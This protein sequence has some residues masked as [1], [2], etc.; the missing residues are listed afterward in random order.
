MTV[1]AGLCSTPAKA[2]RTR[3]NALLLSLA[4]ELRTERV[5]FTAA[6]GGDSLPL[7]PL[8]ELSPMTMLAAQLACTRQE[9]DW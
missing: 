3:C 5:C 8:C 9:G 4:L 7:P 2:R 1:L 6:S